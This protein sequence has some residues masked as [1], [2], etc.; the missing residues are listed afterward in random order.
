MYPWCRT[1]AAHTYRN[2]HPFQQRLR[3]ALEEM[4]GL[5][6]REANPGPT[7]GRRAIAFY[8]NETLVHFIVAK[9]ATERANIELAYVAQAA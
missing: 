1:D 2:H 4:G 3:C 6:H 7:G 5:L 9:S 8:L